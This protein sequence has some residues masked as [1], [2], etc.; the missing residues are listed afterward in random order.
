M[1]SNHFKEVKKKGQKSDCEAGQKS[2][3]KKSSKIFY[4]LEHKQRNRLKSK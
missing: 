4:L 3:M 2:K 1:Q